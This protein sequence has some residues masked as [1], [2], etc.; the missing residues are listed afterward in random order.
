MTIVLL[1]PLSR[2]SKTISRLRPRLTRYSTV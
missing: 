2:S 1:M